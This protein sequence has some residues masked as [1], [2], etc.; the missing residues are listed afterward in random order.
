MTLKEKVVEARK[1][2]SSYSKIK[3]E[4]GVAK[5]TAQD[6]YRKANEYPALFEA[7]LEMPTVTPVVN[8]YIS[9]D[10]SKRFNKNE[11]DVLDF[12]E[13]LAP[14]NVS[15]SYYGNNTSELTDYAVVGSD[16]HFGC[17]DESA[18]NIFLETIRQI[19]PKTVIL[20][21]DTMDFLAISKYPKDIHRCWSLQDERIAYHS[22]LDSL[23]EVAGGADIYETV[24][25]HSGQSVD[26]RWRRYLSERLGEL[27]SL[28]GIA[29]VLSYENVFMG[30][31]QDFVSHVDYVKL[32]DLIVTHGTTVRSTGGASC[33]VEV[34][35]WNTSVL[36]GHTHRIGQSVK[37][38]PNVS[39]RGEQQLIGIEG[40]CLCDLNPLYSACPNW[41]QGFNIISLG[42][43]TFGCEQVYIRNGAANITTLGKTIWG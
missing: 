34:N 25:N 23:I 31:Y 38:V 17:H 8:P 21:G 18:I 36:H 1:D 14:I 39:G 20:N 11:E 43:E 5:S 28:S 10:K 2:G 24:S 19:R 40:G 9:R 22:F 30:S 33:L 42:N 13:Q 7:R 4:F 26:G 15:T 12:L 27:S 16:F 37:R 32:N 35:K 6:W 3:K 29:D 41:Q